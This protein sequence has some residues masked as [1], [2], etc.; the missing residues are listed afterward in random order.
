MSNETEVLQAMQS[1]Q[2]KYF[3]EL[4]V[5]FRLVKDEIEGVAASAISGSELSIELRYSD[6]KVL[7]HRYRMGLVPII[8]HELAHFINPVDPDKVLTERLPPEMVKLWLELI[9]A[10][11]ASCSMG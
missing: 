4:N 1:T 11:Y 8:A 3:P 2:I 9:E 10:G 5:T 6:N 7:E